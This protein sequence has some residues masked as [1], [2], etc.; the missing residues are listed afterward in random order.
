MKENK[1]LYVLYDWANEK[2][3]ISTY[4]IIKVLAKIGECLSYGDCVDNFKIVEINLNEV[5]D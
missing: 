5:K 4:S 3:I 2:T 1:M